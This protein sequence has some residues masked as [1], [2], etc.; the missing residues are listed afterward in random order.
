MPTNLTPASAYDYEKITVSSAAAPC[1]KLTVA[2]R[3]TNSPVGAMYV[4]LTVE[5][6]PIRY[7][8]DDVDPTIT[9]GM[10]VNTGA[11]I[12]IRGKDNISKLRMIRQ[13]GVDATVHVHYYR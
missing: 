3:T 9:D 7:R 10:L 1:I 12:E 8:T 2:K 11:S 13:T 5:A 4:V 6:A